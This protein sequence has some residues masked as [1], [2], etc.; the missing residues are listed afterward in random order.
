MLAEIGTEGSWWRIFNQPNLG[1]FEEPEVTG[2]DYP[3]LGVSQAWNDLEH[4]MLKVET[5][6]ATQSR[7]GDATSF[8]VERIPDLEE[9]FIRLDGE[10]F[11]Q[12]RRNDDGSIDIDTDVGDH[13]FQIFTGYRNPPRPKAQRR[14]APGWHQRTRT[15]LQA[16]LESLSEGEPPRS[17]R[18]RPW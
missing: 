5:Y 4:G 17:S 15:G 18:P 9:A 3:T 1:K 10:P 11:F 7:R 16:L 13:S 12:W 8:R 14:G 2:V 6:A